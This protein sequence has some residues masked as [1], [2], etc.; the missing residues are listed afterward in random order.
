MKRHK[1]WLGVAAIP[2]VVACAA[3]KA[4]SGAM[5]ASEPVTGVEW[6]VERVT[7]GGESL[8][9]P[10]AGSPHLRIGTD[11]TAAGNL[12]CNRFSAPVS[13]HG[14]RIAFGALRTTKMACDPA[15]MSFERALARA[16]DGQTLTGAA[17]RGGLTL[18]TGHGDRVHLTRGAP[19]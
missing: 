8:A 16:L 13:V 7:V 10:A 2:L 14:D 11:G 18:T 12:G 17:E 15:R 5:D 19:E 1:Q 9:A 4:D 6:R 3:G